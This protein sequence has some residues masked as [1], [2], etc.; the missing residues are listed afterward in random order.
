MIYRS[1]RRN[2]NVYSPGRHSSIALPPWQGAAG[3]HAL[4][5]EYGPKA[6]G[7]F[8]FIHIPVPAFIS[9]E[10]QLCRERDIHAAEY[11]SAV[12]PAL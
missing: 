2:G 12:I 8:V 6:E 1:G 4:D 11:R 7:V 5:A 10:Q 3:E 9:G